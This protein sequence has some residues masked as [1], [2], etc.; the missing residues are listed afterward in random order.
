M[1]AASAVAVVMVV[2]LVH[3]VFRATEASDPAGL[4]FS[5]R[6][7]RFVANTVSLGVAVT[8]AAVVL[9][10]GMAWLLERT[11]LPL[12]P[13]LGAIAPLPLVVP[14]YVGALAALS[15]F[16]PTGIVARVPGIVGF[17]GS[18]I[19]LSLS[20]YP[21]VL[22]PA[23][24][25]LRGLDPALEEAAR[26]LGDR[27]WRVAAGVVLPQLRLAVL[28]GGLLSFL[29]VLSDFGAV[30]MMRYDTLTRAI[31]LEYRSSFDRAPAALLATLLVVLTLAA[32]TIERR[33]RGRAS[34]A[35]AVAGV[36]RP[37]LTPL[38]W[39]RWP[40]AGGV[41]LVVT[42][43]LGVPVGV[44]AYWAITG[45]S[46]RDPWS[47]L[48]RAAVTSMSW[49]AAAALAAVVLSVPVAFL[50]VRHRSRVSQGI[51][52]LSLSGYALPGLVIALALVFI[53]ARFLPGI[54]QTGWLVVMAYVVRF[55]PESLGAVRTS[56]GQVDPALED[57]ARS[58]G[59]SRLS[60]VS[61]VTV[62]L[63]RPGLLAGGALVFLTAMKELPATLLL[64]PAG[65]DTLAVRVW[66]G[67]S[68]GRY[69]QA[70]PAALILVAASSLVLWAMRST[71]RST[72]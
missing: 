58:L 10:V 45:G 20:T 34:V 3:L 41:L 50:A 15:A 55:F 64:R 44:S 42:G 9:G 25:A 4:V 14:T 39:A 29:Y 47:V 63:I 5:A 32:I 61:T 24:A 11:D 56:L 43:G 6:V 30:A 27:R 12:R 62:P 18:F 1:I 21:Y 19:V 36:G 54:Y 31:F 2:P 8:A 33:L 52:A 66:T 60:A 53:A 49:S 22:L 59:R 37:Q 23:R 46:A 13:L 17:W 65:A 67:A 7:G 16:G 70:A 72:S 38:G 35:R 69:A 71:P 40:A 68:E 28:A 57:A 51:E 26:A 48:G